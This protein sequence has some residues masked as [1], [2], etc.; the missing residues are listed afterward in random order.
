MLH[1]RLAQ[2]SSMHQ[3]VF[4]MGPPGPLRRQLVLTLAELCGWEVEYMHISK[5]TTESDI[6]QVTT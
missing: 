6:K 1:D 3:D 4:L 5:D 2:K